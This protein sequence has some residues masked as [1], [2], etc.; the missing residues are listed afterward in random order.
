MPY[1]IRVTLVALAIACLAA[2]GMAALVGY[3]H[4]LA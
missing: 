3:P 1:P 4:I 2:F